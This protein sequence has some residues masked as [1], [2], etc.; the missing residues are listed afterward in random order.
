MTF[1]QTLEVLIKWERLESFRTEKDVCPR[2]GTFVILPLPPGD[3][4][5]PGYRVQAT[6]TLCP[7]ATKPY[8]N[9]RISAEA[10]MNRSSAVALKTAW[11]AT[12]PVCNDATGPMGLRPEWG[13][14]LQCNNC[15]SF[16]TLVEEA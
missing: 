8:V 7:D 14:E 6:N 11:F 1:S 4:A 3:P 5:G 9:A 2:T 12:C 10:S 16:F 13:A 15:L